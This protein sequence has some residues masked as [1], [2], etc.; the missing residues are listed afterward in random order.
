MKEATEHAADLA[1]VPQPAGAALPSRRSQQDVTASAQAVASTAAPPAAVRLAPSF[2]P[3][4]VRGLASSLD[5]EDGLRNH[6]YPAHF[7]AVSASGGTVA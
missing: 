2:K 4:R 5:L 1:T 7:S 6:W 3:G